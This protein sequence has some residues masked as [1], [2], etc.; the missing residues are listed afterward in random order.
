MSITDKLSSRKPLRALR[1]L[2]YTNAP[3]C[4]YRAY[5]QTYFKKKRVAKNYSD[6]DQFKRNLD[7]A[8]F[9]NDWFTGHIPYWN[10]IFSRFKLRDLEETRALEI[11]SWEGMS[12]LFI[13]S[14]LP[15]AR[16]ISVDTW[17]GADEHQGT[18][19]L[20]SIEQSFDENI[21]PYKHRSEKF[22]GTSYQFFNQFLDK[23]SLDL[24]YIDG[25]HHTD[26]VII[27]A[28]KAYQLLRVGGI[29]IFDDY[30]WTYYEN[31]IDNP[32]AAINAFLRLKQGSFEI[33]SVYGQVILRKTKSLGL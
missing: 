31:P 16:L 10:E 11:G 32:A 27:D 5:I 28:V 15:N 26:D 20:K 3:A 12:S 19:M 21:R 23:E 25:S 24:I 9:S 17:M 7:A 22:K 33:L 18:S 30:F 6:S 14:M 29:M 4:V 8:N 2:F 13:L 1:Y